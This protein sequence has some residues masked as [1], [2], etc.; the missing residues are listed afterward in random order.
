MF[1]F[2]CVIPELEGVA[3]EILGGEGGE[4]GFW[5]RA[6]VQASVRS[7]GLEGPGW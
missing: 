2:K 3:G 7:R 5:G 4:V 6:S 1:G